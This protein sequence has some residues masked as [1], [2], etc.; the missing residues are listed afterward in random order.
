M[1]KP[2]C[3]KTQRWCY[4]MSCTWTRLSTAIII[5]AS[6]KTK[7]SKD[8]FIFYNLKLK[9]KMV[10]V[11][12]SKEIHFFSLSFCL[13][14]KYLCV[15]LFSYLYSI[16]KSLS[17][18]YNIRDCLIDKRVLNQGKVTHSM[19]G[20]CSLFPFWKQNSLF[21][22]TNHDWYPSFFLLER[23][24]LKPGRRSRLQTKMGFSVLL[25]HLTYKKIPLKSNSKTIH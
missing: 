14:L 4:A 16:F 10:Q 15:C 6:L 23:L 19:R 25:V 21:C 3:F 8:I 22:A 18:K 11:G 24:L 5:T 1:L 13:V 7:F 17:I 20:V 9:K 12:N 2:R